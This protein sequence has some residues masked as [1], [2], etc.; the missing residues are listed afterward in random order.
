MAVAGRAKANAAA[1]VEHIRATGLGGVSKGS[2]R[3]AADGALPMV[4]PVVIKF[5]D[6]DGAPDALSHPMRPASPP[7]CAGCG[8]H[9]HAAW[10]LPVPWDCHTLCPDT[11]AAAPLPSGRAAPPRWPPA[12]SPAAWC[13]GHWPR[14]LRCSTAL[15]RPRPGCC[16]WF[17][18]FPGRWGSSQWHPPQTGLAHRPVRRL[19]FPIHPAQLLA[20]GLDPLPY[21]AKQSNPLPPLEG[22]VDSA[23]IPQGTGQLI[24]LAT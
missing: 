19:P 4:P 16:A 17:P 20:T 21:P 9:S 15:R 10:P 13:R 11:D 3:C 1:R 23:V 18:A 12:Y 24:P 2:S 6:A 14:P 22:P 7:Q 5:V 8:L